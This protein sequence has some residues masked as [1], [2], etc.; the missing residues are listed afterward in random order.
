MIFRRTARYLA[1]LSLFTLVALGP[2]VGVASPYP[3]FILDLDQSSV[4]VSGNGCSNNCSVT[5]GFTS[6]GTKMISFDHESD[7]VA[8]RDLLVWQFSKTA[9]AKDVYNVAVNL[10]FTAPD[11]QVT[12][13]TGTGLFTTV[14]GIFTTGS[15]KWTSADSSVGFNQ[16]SELAYW[17]ESQAFGFGRSA[18]SDVYLQAEKL[19][20]L[21]APSP[22]P[23]PPAIPAMLLALAALL[24][25][26]RRQRSTGAVPA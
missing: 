8:L 10:A 25:F 16:G 26:G 18:T 11:G 9:F 5:G 6:S 17:M 3:N 7:V 4:T 15:F 2:K 22:A 21:A 12:T 14:L 13:T 1:S 19:V 24:Y 23:V 20:P